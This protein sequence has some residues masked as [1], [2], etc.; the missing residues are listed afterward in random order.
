MRESEYNK[1]IG[2]LMR[3]LIIRTSNEMVLRLLFQL[4]VSSST[5]RSRYLAMASERAEDFVRA[6]VLVV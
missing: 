3:N 2:C 1:M 6:V 4:A 5:I